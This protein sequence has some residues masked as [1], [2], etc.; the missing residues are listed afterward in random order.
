MAN[1]FSF[2]NVSL[3]LISLFAALAFVSCSESTLDYEIEPGKPSEKPNSVIISHNYDKT[4]DGSTT[5][6]TD[7]INGACVDGDK[8]IVSKDSKKLIAKAGLDA[9][10]TE[11]FVKSFSLSRK[12]MTSQK[13]GSVEKGITDSSYVDTHVYTN[14]L[15]INNF[16]NV[17]KATLKLCKDTIVANGFKKGTLVPDITEP[18]ETTKDG[19]KYYLYVVTFSS[20]NPHIS[21][22]QE[23]DAKN[24]LVVNFY[25][26]N[27]NYIPEK[28]IDYVK[29]LDAYQ[30]CNQDSIAYVVQIFYKD[31]TSVQDMFKV[32]SNTT[33]KVSP[34]D[35][36]KFKRDNLTFGNPTITPTA[37]NFVKNVVSHNGMVSINV[38]SKELSVV[39]ASN[40]SYKATAQYPTETTYERPG[41]AAIKLTTFPMS[42]LKAVANVATTNTSATEGTDKY[43]VTKV[44]FVNTLLSSDCSKEA[45]NSGNAWVK[46]AEEPKP[47]P[48]ITYGDRKH[49]VIEIT[50]TSYKSSFEWVT[51]ED[52]KEK[53]FVTITS[54]PITWSVTT[55]DNTVTVENWTLNQFTADLG[56]WNGN[57]RTVTTKTNV[58]NRPFNVTVGTSSWTDPVSKK[59]VAFKSPKSDMVF[60]GNDISNQTDLPNIGFMA[61]KQY[62][63]SINVTVTG[64]F[65]D[66]FSANVIRQMLEM[67]IS[68][69]DTDGDHNVSITRNNNSNEFFRVTDIEYKTGI[70][71]FVNEKFVKFFTYGVDIAEPAK[72]AYLS[73]TVALGKSDWIIT[74]MKKAQGSSYDHYSLMLANQGQVV[75]NITPNQAQIKGYTEGI[76]DIDQTYGELESNGTLVIRYTYTFNAS[77]VTQ[78]VTGAAKVSDL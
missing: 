44:T 58:D 33:L 3:I 76:L 1:L 8:N 60:S 53:S 29:E 66:N 46:E 43:K 64:L 19:K 54:D 24:S 5:T 11:F 45:S 35:L 14:G 21:G 75:C 31:K 65:T 42:S 72:G 36:G 10:K 73:A 17:Q 16:Y 68:E 55:S 63:T 61:R 4:T 48:V 27:N 7:S 74:E 62:T 71:L 34:T 40:P 69:I 32:H 15:E 59:V 37:E 18:V 77:K 67:P 28:E 6:V 52:D 13:E 39:F 26:E 41:A 56:S 2:R 22:K 38:V 25:A 30:V 70:A 49:K 50:K 51:Y 47:E 20:E 57:Q 9:N 78:T 23:L 12:E